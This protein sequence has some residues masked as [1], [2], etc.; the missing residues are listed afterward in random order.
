LVI[1]VVATASVCLAGYWEFE[2]VDSGSLGSYVAIDKTSDG[3]IW[4]AYVNRDSATRLAHKD[5]VWEYEDLDT[6]LVRPDFREFWF[7]PPFSFDIGPGGVIGVVGLGRLAER[8]D[9]GWSS[10]ELPMP[11]SGLSLSYD[12]AGR[13]SLTFRDGLGNV[14]LGLKTDSGWDTN[15]VFSPYSGYTWH[16]NLSRPAWR[17]N[18]DCAFMEGDWWDEAGCIDGDDVNLFTRDSGVWT[19]YT[20]AMG[21]DGGG[22][23][24]A[25]LVDSS[26]SIHTFRSA[27]DPYATDELVC[28][29][30]RLDSWSDK[31]AACLDT[32]GR[33]QCAWIPFIQGGLKFAIPGRG[34]WIVQDTGNLVWCDITTDTMSQP[35]IAFCRDDGS[36]WVAHGVDVAGLS[37]APRE[38]AVRSSRLM[39]T[40]VTG[41]LFLPASG[42]G[43][44]AKG[45][46]LDISGRK[47]INLRPGVNDVSSIASGVYFVRAVS[48]ELSAVGCSKVV[49]TR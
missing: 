6:A 25:A 3:T 11:M 22:S 5:S 14:C 15:V 26:D 1:F 21:L 10:E 29:T 8:R 46:L 44:M 35:V 7:S 33:V 45:E 23:G 28:D 41:V 24:F 16:I 18:G 37:D 2:Q 19:C 20:E 9:S 27:E 42:E 43:R 40:I 39:S 12:L 32:V 17:R 49:V 38:L 47:V 34:T 36:I 13:P 30:F 31:G 4:L 48:R